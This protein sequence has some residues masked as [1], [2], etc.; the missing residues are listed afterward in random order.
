M[1]DAKYAVPP[2]DLKD[3][4]LD[5]ST[6]LFARNGTNILD[7]NLPLKSVYDDDFR[8]NNNMINDELCDDPKAELK[9]AEA[10]YLKVISEKTGFFFV[11]GYGGTGKTFLWNA[12]ISSLRGKERV[13]L[14]VAS[15]GVASLLLPGG[16]TAHSRFKIPI[17]LDDNGTCDI[18]RSTKLA[19]LIESASLI[20]WD[21]ALM[22]HRR[23]FEAL[24]RSLRDILPVGD[25]SL[26][27][28]PFGGKII[29]LAGDLRQ[30]LP[31]IEGG[32]RSQIV[33]AAITN[34]PLWRFIEVLKLSIN[35]RLAVQTTDPI[36]QAEVASFAEWILSIG[37]G[38]VPA[39]ARK[40]EAEPSWIT[41]PDDILIHSEGDNRI[42][43][44]VQAVYTDFTANCSNPRYLRE[45]AILTTTNDLALEVNDHV[46]TLLPCAEKEY[47]SYDSI[48]NAAEAMRNSDVFILLNI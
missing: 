11:S 5:K 8:D 6:V 22:T 40:G 16:R 20:I 7:H 30:I 47:L 43:A 28:M 12:I 36:L 1:R 42:D 15:S 35:M 21:E 14:T 4:L 29:V 33:N 18:K 37:D 10:M 23:C 39:V 13:V 19:E 45:R 31:A 26:A 2:N 46:L 34:S 3:M 48:G 38:T 9:K 17:C 41:I 27:D 25:P 24:D 44:I 32:T